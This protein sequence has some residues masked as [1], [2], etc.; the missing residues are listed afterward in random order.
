MIAVQGRVRQLSGIIG[1]ETIVKA[2]RNLINNKS[3]PQVSLFLGYPG[4][5]KTTLAEILASSILCEKP[6]VDKQGNI[7]PCQE[8]K[9]CKAVY[10]QKSQ[11][12]YYVYNGVTADDTVRISETMDYAPSGKAIVFMLNELHDSSAKAIDNLKSI[13]ERNLNNVY[14]IITSSDVERFQ[15]FTKDNKS[16]EKTALSSRMMTFSIKPANQDIMKKVLLSVLLQNDPEGKLP[17]TIYDVMALLANNA[18]NSIRDAINKFESLLNAKIYTEEEARELLGIENDEAEM[19][20]LLGLLAYKDK[21]FLR[22]AQKKKYDVVFP[23][24]FTALT[25]I[26]EAE[27]EGYETKAEW[28]VKNANLIKK[29]GNLDILLDIFNDINTKFAF[30]NENYFKYKLYKFYIS[31]KK[32]IENEK[33]VKVKIPRS[34]A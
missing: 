14:F 2:L 7:E 16:N 31:E 28:Q 8:C 3:V 26:A 6:H 24:L 19:Y 34:L 1:N 21:T 4:N 5:G 10:S 15:A 30:F 18:H 27:I 29:S 32:L 12:D 9:Y 11:L 22:E 23:Y 25:N 33:P 13:F 17:E 20:R